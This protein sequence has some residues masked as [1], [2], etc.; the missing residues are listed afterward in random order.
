[1]VFWLFV[2]WVVVVFMTGGSARG[3]ISTML[4]LRPAAVLVCAILLA[5][6]AR[7]DLRRN[8]SLLALIVAAMALVAFH[9]VPLPPALW[10]LLPER[11]LIAR[12]DR[13]VGLGPTWRPLTLSPAA[14]WNAL[15]ALTVP[16]SVALFMSR[17]EPR[18]WRSLVGPILG[19]GLA[20]IVLGL[21]QT[22]TA[23]PESALYPYRVSNFGAP[24]GLF[25][26]RNHTGAFLAAMLPLLAVFASF[27]GGKD[28]RYRLRLTVALFGAVTVLMFLLLLGSRAGLLLGLL[29]LLSMPLIHEGAG[30]RLPLKRRTIV[31]I[32]AAIV[33]AL[34][35]VAVSLAA[36]RDES[37]ER[38]FSVEPGENYRVTTFFP[39]LELGAQYFPLGSGIGTFVTT[40]Q[41]HEPEAR[42][43][44]RYLNHAHN[45]PLELWLTGGVPALVL[46]AL[47]VAI[48]ARATIKAFRAKGLHGKAVR[49][50]NAL[51]VKKAAGVVLCLFALASVVDYPL[52]T[53]A[54][55]ALAAIML[56]ILLR[57]IGE[58][59][60]NGLRRRNDGAASGEQYE[61]DATR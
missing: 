6:A 51:A 43:E 46:A 61:T 57:P 35:V 56:A 31:A 8:Q 54:L 37:L 9:L 5:T 10:Q 60:G 48:V 18:R 42:L 58:R 26:N 24:I 49:E 16:L 22:T 25:A 4:V 32:G 15:Y 20:S 11:E 2:G 14:T 17:I 7:E 29:G 45:E 1:M 44:P 33:G 39:L 41:V 12:I 21:L 27:R 50:N 36:S 30:N 52:R 53:P 55:S 19:L 38:L 59:G 40:W 28:A 47:V 13:A 34:A 3:D 23:N